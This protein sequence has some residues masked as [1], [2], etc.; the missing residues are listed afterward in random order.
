MGVLGLLPERVA[1][2]AV[3]GVTSTPSTSYALTPPPRWTTV[4]VGALHAADASRLRSLVSLV[5]IAPREPRAGDAGGC[6]T[7]WRARRAW[8][9]RLRRSA[10][11][12]ECARQAQTNAVSEGAALAE[13]AAECHKTTSASQSFLSGGLSPGSPRSASARRRGDDSRHRARW[14]RA[15]S[16]LSRRR[17][18]ARRAFRGVPGARASRPICPPTSPR[19]CCRLDCSAATRLRSSS[20]RWCCGASARWPPT[21]DD[22][23]A[24]RGGRRAVPRGSDRRARP[25]PARTRAR[26]RR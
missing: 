1:D 21:A 17:Q 10:A 18:P 5:A 15:G 20:R 8:S 24:H 22:L 7:S 2:G 26:A 19:R 6:D 4:A 16:R 13:T 25:R 11:A 12:V 23:R 9:R 3:G 14:I